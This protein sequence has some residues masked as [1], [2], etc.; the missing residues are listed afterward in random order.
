[1]VVNIEEQIRGACSQECETATTFDFLMFYMKAWKYTC[2]VEMEKI[3]GK[4]A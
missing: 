1:M 3:K 2:Q 4:A